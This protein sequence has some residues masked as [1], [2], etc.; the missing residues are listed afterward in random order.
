MIFIRETHHIVEW[1][2]RKQRYLLGWRPYKLN[3]DSI[4]RRAK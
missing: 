4:Y 3:D 2:M 1:W